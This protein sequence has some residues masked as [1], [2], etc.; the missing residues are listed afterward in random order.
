MILERLTVILPSILTVPAVK[1]G[2]VEQLLENFIMQNE[3]SPQYYLDVVAHY[4]KEAK[5]KAK[6]YKYAVYHYIKLPD[7][8]IRGNSV[9]YNK[10]N[11]YD[12]PDIWE[13][14][15][16][17]KVR[18]IDNKKILIEGGNIAIKMQERFPDK[19]I[20]FHIHSNWKIPR[21]KLKLINSS[22]SIICVSD[23]IRQKQIEQGVLP[24]RV[25]T[26]LNGIDV[27]HFEVNS[28][29][30]KK[31]LKKY[32]VPE[33]AFVLLYK[34]R[35]VKEKGIVELIHAFE[36]MDRENVYLIIAGSLNFG[37]KRMNKSKYEK[38]INEL[39]QNND[40]IIVTGHI[41]Y[42]KIMELHSIS[43][44]AVVPS[45]WEEPC[46]LV[47]IEALVS[48]IP[49]VTTKK[50]GIPEL[51][52]NTGAIVLEVDNNF[53]NNLKDTL[54]TLYDNR[55]LLSEMINIKNSQLEFFSNKRYFTDIC[56]EISENT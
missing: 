44:V 5:E 35:L 2:A 52:K 40:K 26:V 10:L 1:G 45:L 17:R 54:C 33:D 20:F 23:F 27:E 21:K 13:S 37:Q 28:K 4:K 11:L 14:S 8:I 6:K 30:N 46:A 22:M 43:T 32:G 19:K 47:V 29:N 55:N 9:L 53:I 56:Q 7:L 24:S 15:I 49:L 36:K 31:A 50:G 51:C 41:D 38:E 18:K 34:G 42:D 48:K 16:I 3:I 12:I 39:V 25:K